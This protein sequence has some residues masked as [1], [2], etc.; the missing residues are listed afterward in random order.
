MYEALWNRLTYSM[1]NT[2][3]DIKLYLLVLVQFATKTVIGNTI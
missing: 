3:N 2:M 1:A